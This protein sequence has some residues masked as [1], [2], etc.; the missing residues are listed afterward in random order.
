M[1]VD[2][3][4][5]GDFSSEMEWYSQRIPLVARL[6]PASVFLVAVVVIAVVAALQPIFELR[7]IL[8]GIIFIV[9]MAA[10]LDDL[11]ESIQWVGIGKHEVV[12]VRGKKRKVLVP[13]TSIRGLEG[14]SKSMLFVQPAFVL[15]FL[16]PEGRLATA[17]VLPEIASKLNAARRSSE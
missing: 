8:I 16:T 2:A 10:I 12:L 17:T 14:P 6:A 9:S 5:S 15:H 11:R 3:S 7:I 1:T 13:W 4:I